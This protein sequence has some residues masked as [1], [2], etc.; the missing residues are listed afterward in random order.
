VAAADMLGLGFMGKHAVK[1]AF[2]HFDAN[3]N[4]TLEMQ[5]AVAAMEK[6]AGQTGF[7]L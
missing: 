4:G 1:M 6:L 3:K 5:E 2:R 7:K